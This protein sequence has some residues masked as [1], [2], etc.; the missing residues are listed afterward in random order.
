M[1]HRYSI[2]IYNEYTPAPTDRVSTGPT[3][4]RARTGACSGKKKKKSFFQD[5]QKQIYLIFFSGKQTPSS[6]LDVQSQMVEGTLK[7]KVFSFFLERI[8]SFY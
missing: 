8:V 1:N 4:P 3:C 5:L 6:R 2:D 7:K